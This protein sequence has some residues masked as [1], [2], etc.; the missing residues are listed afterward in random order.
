MRRA[1]ANVQ[2][3][4]V[5]NGFLPPMSKTVAQPVKTPCFVKK[6]Y[7][8]GILKYVRHILKYL[9]HIFE[10]VREGLK[11]GRPGEIT[12]RFLLHPAHKKTGRRRC[13]YASRCVVCR[14]VSVLILLLV[15]RLL[16]AF[17]KA[18]GLV[19]GK[20][21]RREQAQYVCARRAREHMLVEYQA[22]A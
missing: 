8:P 11:T 16:Q 18:V 9:R 6:N 22:P 20:A 4:V 3:L 5:K 19:N 15:E 13:R 12:A 21:Q 7:V 10:R 14:V 2:N 1:G 17:H